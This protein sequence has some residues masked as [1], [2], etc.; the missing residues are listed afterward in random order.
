MTASAAVLSELLTLFLANVPFRV[1][2]TFLVSRLC[3]WA[4]VGILC[5]MTLVVLASFLYVRWPSHRAGAVPAIDPSTIAGAVY[6]V[7]DSW[8]L[9]G[10]EG[11]GTIKRGERDWRVESRGEKYEFGEIVGV[12]GTPRVAVDSVDTRVGGV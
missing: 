1:T 4:A 7:A 5:V 8:M 9:A 3:T 2:Q 10:L 12:S 6:Y 11:I